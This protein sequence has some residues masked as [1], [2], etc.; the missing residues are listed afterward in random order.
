MVCEKSSE[1]VGVIVYLSLDCS[2]GFWLQTSSCREIFL[3]VLD[4]ARSAAVLLPLLAVAAFFSWSL[5]FIAPQRASAPTG[6]V[7]SA[8]GVAAALVAAA[9]QPASAFSETERFGTWQGH[10]RILTE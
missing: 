2:Q 4:M 7:V 8:S 9:P 3:R 5:T 10:C 1:W 6:P